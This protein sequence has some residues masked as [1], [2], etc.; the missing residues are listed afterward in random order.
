MEPTPYAG[1]MTTTAHPD[2]DDVSAGPAPQMDRA[3]YVVDAVARLHRATHQI[4]NLRLQQWNMSLS[5]YTALRIM[6]NRPDLSLAQLSRRCFVR[7]QTM[8]RIVTQLEGRG[9]VERHP[10]PENERALSLRP[11]E[12][13]LSAL[14]KMDEEVNKINSTITQVLDD[15]QIAQLDTMLRECARLVETEIKETTQ[16]KS[17]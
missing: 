1:Q 2:G 7:P 10:R 17:I 6:A 8:T 13:G 11:T 3:T 14:A 5:S 9:F 15:D 4:G 12:K 16:S